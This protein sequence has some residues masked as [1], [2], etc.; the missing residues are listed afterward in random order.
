MGENSRPGKQNGQKRTQTKLCRFIEHA[1]TCPYGE[2]CTYSHDIANFSNERVKSSNSPKEQQERVDY[3]AWKRIIKSPPKQNDLAT[4]KRL[5]TGALDILE[6]FDRNWKQMLPRDLDADEN[7][8]REHIQ[9]LLSMK[10]HGNGCRTFVELS[11]PFLAVITH[12]SMLDCLSIDTAVGGLYNF[13]SGTNGQ[14]AVGFFTRICTNLTRAYA[15]LVIPK[16]VAE[17]TLTSVGIALH[18]L[19]RREQRAVYNDELPDLVTSL[20]YAANAVEIDTQFI[21]FNSSIAEVR[22]RIG[23]AT[24]L[25]KDKEIDNTATVDGISTATFKSSYPRP[26][27][28]PG[29]RHDND[30]ADITKIRIMPTNE[31]I[32][33]E[34]PDYLPTT[35]RDQ[36][37]F[38]TNATER[39]I[40]TLFRLLRHD[41]FGELKH[42]LGILIHAMKEDE[43]IQRTWKIPVGDIRAYAY[44]NACI[45]YV[46]FERRAGIEAQV[47][48]SQ[49]PALRKK[50]PA[51]R[52][53]WWA[54]SK[55]LE[56]GIL[57]CFVA[58]S[59]GIP[60]ILFLTVGKKITDLK[61]SR[62]LGSNEY[63]ATVTTKLV[64]RNQAEFALLTELSSKSTN[65]VLFEFPGVIPATFMPILTNLQAMQLSG[66]IPFSQW[67]L[68]DRATISGEPAQILPPLYAR[69]RSYFFLL[70]PILTRQGDSLSFSPTTSC[71][72]AILRNLEER[73][74]LDHGQCQALIAALTREC[75]TN[76]ALDQFLEELIK[77]GV[78][79]LIRIGGQSKSKI[80]EGHNLRV[81]SNGERKTRN[82]SFCAART[83]EAL[84]TKEPLIATSLGALHA[85]RKEQ[86][87]GSLKAN[88]LHRLKGHIKQRYPLAF[89]E[90]SQVG[91]DGY[92]VAGKDPFD[93]WCEKA[94]PRELRARFSA[95]E[96]ANIVQILERVGTDDISNLPI[97]ERELLINFWAR[98]YC[99]IHRDQLFELVDECS[100]LHEQLDRIHDER[101]RRVLEDAEVIGVTTTGLAKR[102]SVLRR[103]RSKVVICEE[104]GEVM[105]PHMISALLPNVEHFIQIGDHQQLR[106]QIN[107]YELSLE[108]K[109][110]GAYQL[111]RS[112]FERL[113]IGEPGRA[114][115]PVAQLDTQRRMRPEISRLI[116]MTL[117]P[118]LVDHPS[119][120]T[121]PDVVGMR[122]NVFWLDYENIEDSS[123]SD[124]HQ[125]SHSN[126]WEVDMT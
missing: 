10:S 72:I 13:I 82:E 62:N 34:L 98:E 39:H 5:W 89:N 20:E 73:T 15:Q 30:H 1:K 12:P 38:I 59:C 119:T 88:I 26:I 125:M 115:F 103:L 116:R 55:R 107:N 122:N 100:K 126:S 106:P 102:I 22:A 60:S 51:E 54:D 41:I 2:N 43:S 95:N 27:T 92:K 104:A 97:P 24:G 25:L 3:N 19:L 101:D 58:V 36:P 76:H 4:I 40:D 118:R 83:Y 48:F 14:R 35:D 78:K 29:T 65:G 93:V 63:N 112:Q 52:S 67:I 57:L 42:A 96:E 71:N 86:N 79:K 123:S 74:T 8:G 90:F 81:V 32:C 64:T 6:G 16:A 99:E 33:C 105:E 80:L 53:K 121:F 50:T 11:Q 44:P 7:F 75:Y 31:E 69:N 23:R 70:D 109:Q 108:S 113:S 9:I 21:R 120:K 110:G 85:L 17:T 77:A 124:R 87:W 56:E 94:I 47:S 68:P 111:D 66:Y 61:E 46:S 49:L 45:Q 117:Y 84:R 37:S 28:V 114:P 18:E 91:G